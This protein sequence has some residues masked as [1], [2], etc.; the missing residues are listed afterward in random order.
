MREMDKIWYVVPKHIE[1]HYLDDGV[2]IY[3]RRL[4]TCFGLEGISLEIWKMMCNGDSAGNIIKNIQEKYD[5]EKIRVEADIEPF[6]NNLLQH[7]LL[8]K[9]Q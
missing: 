8:E 6:I 4:G 1:T 7:K 2:F 9:A 5:V 3:D